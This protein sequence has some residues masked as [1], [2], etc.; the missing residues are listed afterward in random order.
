VQEPVGFS[1][2]QI[3][4]PNP[5][6]LAIIAYNLFVRDA[7]PGIREKV[8]DSRQKHRD[9]IR[10]LLLVSIGQQIDGHLARVVVAGQQIAEK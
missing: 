5:G 6:V 9:E 4:A 8:I 1:Q 3:G 10:S 7:R 2:S